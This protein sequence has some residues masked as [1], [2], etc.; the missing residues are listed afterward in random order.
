M[1]MPWKVRFSR[2]QCRICDKLF[3]ATCYDIRCNASA[4]AICSK[5]FFNLYKPLTVKY[6]QNSERFGKVCFLC[7]TCD[8]S[9]VKKSPKECY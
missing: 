4:Q 1:Y 2:V 9:L 7:N 5:Y 6:G 3:H 8:L